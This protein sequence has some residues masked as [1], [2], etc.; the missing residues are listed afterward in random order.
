MQWRDSYALRL[1]VFG[2]V[3]RK[4]EITRFARSL[5]T[6]LGNGVPIVTAVGIANDT[7]GNRKLRAA[8]E[9][10]VPSIKQGGRLADALE[11]TGLFTP[12]ALNMVR[13]AKTDF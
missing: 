13:F 2:E 10:I 6:L 8:M 7:M 12:L 1:P 5:G 3:V 9:G 11:N 4:Y